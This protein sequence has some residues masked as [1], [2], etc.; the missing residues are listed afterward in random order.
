MNDQHLI[1][2]RE[3]DDQHAEIHDVA[4]SLIEAVES[5]DKWHLIH[6]ILVRLN[7]LLRFHFSVEESVMRIVNFPDIDDHKVKHSEI[8]RE[9]EKLLAS[10]LQSK[11]IQVGAF[12]RQHVFF[13][14]H[15][16]DH[17]AK[18]GEFIAGNTALLGR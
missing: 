18:L 12:S 14:S 8:L 5:G 3:I 2:I 1:G 4:M 13:L 16:L 7:H 6:Y 17:D 10:T 15:I 11:E 9:V